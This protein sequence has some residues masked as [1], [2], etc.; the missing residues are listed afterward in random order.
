M[1]FLAR[2]TRSAMLEVLNEDYIRTARSNGLAEKIVIYRH[3][4]KMRCC[5]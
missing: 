3:G 1:A 5:P 4:L 2:V